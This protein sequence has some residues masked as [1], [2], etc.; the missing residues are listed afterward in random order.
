M[1]MVVK[2]VK[3]SVFNAGDSLEDFI[4][5][6]IPAVS[7]GN[8]IVVTSKIVAVSQRRIVPGGAA[9]KASWIKKESEKYLKTKWC[10]LTLKDGQWCANAGIDE[11]NSQGGG[12]ILLPKNPYRDAMAL[13]KKLQKFYRVKK[14][15]VIITDSRIFPLR[16]GV[17]GVAIG[18]AGFQGIRNYI[19]S[20][21]LFGRRIKMTKTNVADS[22][23]TAAVLEM[24]EGDEQIPLAVI[25]GIAQIVFTER[26]R[27][28][29]LQMDP[30]N[31]L[32]RPLFRRN[33]TNSAKTGRRKQ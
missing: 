17:T 11:S 7:E 19:G 29:E 33:T 20:K 13:R 22:L 23:A 21:D 27:K 10:Y 12:L 8:I 30:K 25:T 31:D 26:V 3:T 24:G 2:P 1:T 15:G 9:Q 4:V 6:F 32:Y 18:Y 5:R 14:L 16:Q 28:K